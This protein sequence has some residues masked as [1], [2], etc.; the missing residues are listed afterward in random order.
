M[1]NIQNEL[2]KLNRKL[3]R[4]W[5][6]LVRVSRQS[7]L[8]FHECS[9]SWKTNCTNKDPGLKQK[10]QSKNY[11]T[12]IWNYLM[13]IS[14]SNHQHTGEKQPNLQTQA[15]IFLTK[16]ITPPRR[17]YDDPPNYGSLASPRLSILRKVPGL[18]IIDKRNPS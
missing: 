15:S 11:S 8:K 6:Y 7:Q 18:V 10:V 2:G 17:L 4:F 14:K 3:K 13:G 12:K 1:V 5:I 16:D 9:C